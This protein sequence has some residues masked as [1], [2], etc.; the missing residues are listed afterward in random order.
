VRDRR[1]ENAE[2]GIADE[3]LEAASVPLDLSANT[4]VVRRQEGA[5]VLGVEL[6]GS[7]CEAD[8]V[9]EQDAEDPPLFA[10][11]VLRQCR[12]AVQAESGDLGVLLTAGAT[13]RHAHRL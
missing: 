8:E 6:L 1:A 2:H 7:R 12:A 4:L 3:F 13:D 11:D 10:V 5:N 9:D